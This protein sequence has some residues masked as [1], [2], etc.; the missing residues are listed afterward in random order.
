MAV[1]LPKPLTNITSVDERAA[2]IDT[3]RQVARPTFRSVTTRR[4]PRSQHIPDSVWESH[5]DEISSLYRQSK[6]GDLMNY[7]QS[8]HNF[9]PS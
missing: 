7:M 5:H 8:K 3:T 1:L 6:L 4:K 2:V 9:N